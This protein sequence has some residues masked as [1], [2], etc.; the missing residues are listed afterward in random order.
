MRFRT[1]GG[2]HKS[3]L[4][5]KAKADRVLLELQIR[6]LTGYAIELEDAFKE[7][8]NGRLGDLKMS[9]ETNGLNAINITLSK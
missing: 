6:D 9:V 8:F 3:V 5:K 4:N 1:D 2:G 7:H